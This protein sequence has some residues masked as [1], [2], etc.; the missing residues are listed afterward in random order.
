MTT[1]RGGRPQGRPLAEEHR[2]HIAE[3]MRGRKLAPEHRQQIAAA[4]RGKTKT[5]EHRAA[6]SA[7]KRAAFEQQL[8][9]DA[10]LLYD[11]ALHLGKDTIVPIELQAETDLSTARLVSVAKRLR[12][13][14][15]TGLTLHKV[16]EAERR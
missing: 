1:K 14:R 3:A 16:L 8:L 6:I 5:P 4:M 13:A 12:R 7:A 2:Q 9:A 11:T 15:E 10:Q